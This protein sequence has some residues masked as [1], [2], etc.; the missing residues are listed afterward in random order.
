MIVSVSKLKSLNVGGKVEKGVCLQNYTTFKLGG[1]AKYMIC[2]STLEGLIKVMDYINGRKQKFFVLGAGSNLLVS[3]KGYDGLVINLDGDFA[4]LEQSLDGLTSIGAG[5]RLS[6]AYSIIKD[7]GFSGLEVLATIPA[8]IG[9]AV[10]MNAGAFCEQISDNIEYVVALVDGKIT[11]FSRDDCNFGYR[12]S[13][14]QSLHAIILRVGF[15]FASKDKVKIEEEFKSALQRKRESQPLEYPSAG[16]VF[17]AIDGV[18]VS[19]MLDDMNIKG[20]RIGGAVVSDK[21][22]NFILNRGGSANDVYR[23]INKIKFMFKEKYNIDLET[24]IKFLGEFE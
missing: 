6:K 1:K 10:Y 4:R 8:T 7:L 22:A 17:K 12:Y 24:E 9:G 11:Y 5:M 15:R 19:K 14:F 3:D 20:M 13:V 23:L 2:I 16:S 21:H 18:V